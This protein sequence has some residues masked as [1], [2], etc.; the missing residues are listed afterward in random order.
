MRER[1]ATEMVAAYLAEGGWEP[2]VDHEG[3]IRFQHVG[4]PCMIRLDP[5]DPCFVRLLVPICG[6]GTS[7]PPP[8]FARIAS[9]VAQEVKA[10]KIVRIGDAAWASVELMCD[11]LDRFQTVFRRMLHSAQTVLGRFAEEMKAAKDEWK[12]GQGGAA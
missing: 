8:A 9:V 4:W 12:A 10:A 3:Q 6:L 11:P 7:N 1:T 2:K 5:Q